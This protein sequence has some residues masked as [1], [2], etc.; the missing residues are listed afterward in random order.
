MHNTRRN[1]LLA[2]VAAL[3]LLAALPARADVL[4]TISGAYE[5]HFNNMEDFYN[6]RTGGNVAVP[7]V[8]NENYGL[9]VGGNIISSSG[10]TYGGPG[11]GDDYLVGVFGGITIAA[12]Y[13]GTTPVSTFGPGEVSYATGGEFH[14]Y[15]VPVSDFASVTAFN[16]FMNSTGPSG[17]SS[18]CGTQ[19]LAQVAAGTSFCYNGLTNLAGVK[20]ILDL[21]LQNAYDIGGTYYTLSAGLTA[22]LSGVA[23]GWADVN[24]GTDM[25]KF[26]NATEAAGGLSPLATGTLTDISLIDDFCAESAKC[27]SLYLNKVDSNWTAASSDPYEGATVPEPASVALFGTGLLGLGAALRRRRKKQA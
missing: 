18:G 26:D 5:G 3:T 6:T 14:L 4:S 15:D 22:T 20:D 7:S 23:N 25:A 2:S 11:G 21:G 10:G 17:F 13:N 27:N 9:I 16:N 24:G 1:T 12:I 8:G 19:T